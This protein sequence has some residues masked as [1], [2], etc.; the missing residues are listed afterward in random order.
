VEYLIG[1]DYPNMCED[2]QHTIS[3]CAEL[4][5]M[6]PDVTVTGVRIDDNEA[7]LMFATDNRM[8][9]GGRTCTKNEKVR[10]EIWQVHASVD[11]G[12]EDPAF[13]WD[14]DFAD[15]DPAFARA[16]KAAE[17]KRVEIGGVS[18]KLG[19]DGFSVYRSGQPDTCFYFW[20]RFIGWKEKQ[21]DVLQPA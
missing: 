4:V 14:E 9:C 20:I 2:C 15:F 10:A 11:I 1:K 7:P 6:G 19:A 3:A 12:D 16:E 18:Y 8:L 17:E 5:A 13:L 21:S